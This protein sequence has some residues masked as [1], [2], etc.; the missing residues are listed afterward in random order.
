MSLGHDKIATAIARKAT[1]ATIRP[2]LKFGDAFTLFYSSIFATAA[3][4]DAKLKEERRSDL[5]R[6]IEE[7][8]NDLRAIGET[9]VRT[10]D[11]SRNTYGKNVLANTIP[12]SDSGHNG[13]CQH[14]DQGNWA[15]ALERAG[16]DRGPTRGG[17]KQQCLENYPS[18]TQRSGLVC[19]VRVTD[20]GYGRILLS[21][22]GFTPGGQ[23]CSIEHQPTIDEAGIDT[24]VTT[25]R[26]EYALSE[27]K[28]KGLELS[29]R[30]LVLRLLQHSTV[31]RKVLAPGQFEGG[32]EI[33]KLRERLL[34][35]LGNDL[36]QL[37]E[38]LVGRLPCYTS[39]GSMSRFSGRQLSQNI[40]TILRQGMEGD[41]HLDAVIP[42]ICF[43]LLF[44][45][46]PPS[47][48]T[49][50]ILIT[51]LTRLRRNVLVGIVF[52]WMLE[53]GQTPNNATISALIKFYT[54]SNDRE[55]F[56]RLVGLMG[57]LDGGSPQDD[58]NLSGS[59]DVEWANTRRAQEIWEG[60]RLP[61]EMP[62][63]AYTFGAAIN[64]A[65]KFGM[66]EKAQSWYRAM[67]REGIAP[68]SPVLTSIIRSCAFRREWL[69]GYKTWQRLKEIWKLGA[70]TEECPSI[71]YSWMLRL[72]RW[73]DRRAEFEDIFQESVERGLRGCD[74][75]VNIK[76]KGLPVWNK[77]KS[78]ST[79]AIRIAHKNRDQIHQSDFNLS[80]D[81]AWDKIKPLHGPCPPVSSGTW[82]MLYEGFG[83]SLDDRDLD[84]QRLYGSG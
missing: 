41:L 34:V 46:T 9:A 25:P 21:H 73:C 36:N 32:D 20:V 62:F 18:E 84:D 39:Q 82:H 28:L 58:R 37:P 55:G 7:T 16:L 47:V 44:S 3:V 31:R 54:A 14:M 12:I 17:A 72:C 38:P 8:R 60:Q 56:L 52:D 2:S 63:N 78:P 13:G 24:T 43:N 68:T 10:R 51:Q 50:N 57:G 35:H 42:G 11:I 75:P 4:I 33:Q 26:E 1:T 69:S 70:S 80:Q 5:D 27:E 65:L 67:I 6:M 48:D 45:T 79:R 53:A 23:K 40:R 59:P 15:Y 49:Y 22:D 61:D 64:A 19:E 66:V 74:N 29:I 71:A 83:S 81:E 30:K 76:T 77:V